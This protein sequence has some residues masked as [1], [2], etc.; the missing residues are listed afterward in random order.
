MQKRKDLG[1]E[2]QPR[3]LARVL[4]EQLCNI[5]GGHDTGPTSRLSILADGRKDITN[6]ESD[7]DG[8]HTY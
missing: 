3:V 8:P 6:G 7:N 5:V 4:A 2:P 1:G